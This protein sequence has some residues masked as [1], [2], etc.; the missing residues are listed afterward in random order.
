MGKN[1]L[2][3]EETEKLEYYHKRKAEFETLSPEEFIKKRYDLK[4]WLEY[5]KKFWEEEGKKIVLLMEGK[6]NELLFYSQNIDLPRLRSFYRD[7]IDFNIFPEDI[8]SYFVKLEA[9]GFF[10][11]YKINFK[12]WITMKN[13]LNP[14]NNDEYSFDVNS[15]KEWIEY[16]D[17]GA[18]VLRI[19]LNSGLIYWKIFR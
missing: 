11:Y 6:N 12:T 9:E 8:I 7:A 13:Y 10:D 4:W 14:E 2:T 19:N 17:L 18:D 5:W 16:H 15:P 3:R 1:K